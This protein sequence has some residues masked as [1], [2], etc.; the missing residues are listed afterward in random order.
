MSTALSPISRL[1]KAATDNGFDQ[2]LD[3]EGD[4]PVVASTQCPLRVWLGSFG[5]ALLLA[6]LSQQ[7]VVLALGD[8]SHLALALCHHS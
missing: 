7:N 8:R 1:E 5:D 4:W 3:S 2:V 6:A